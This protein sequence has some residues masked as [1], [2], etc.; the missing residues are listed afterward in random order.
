[1]PSI[2]DTYSDQGDF[3]EIARQAWNSLRFMNKLIFFFTLSLKKNI[4]R[5]FRLS[6]H[7]LHLVKHFY[8]SLERLQK[9]LER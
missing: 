9:L 2:L 4:K 5:K 3:I 7:S 8:K 6:L 1:M